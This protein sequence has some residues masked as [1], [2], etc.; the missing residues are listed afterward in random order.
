MTE[1]TRIRGLVL[2]AMVSM[3]AADGQLDTSEQDTICR[4]YQQITGKVIGEL[5]VAVVA[6]H[7]SK[8]PTKFASE[9]AVA[10]QNIET[11]EKETILRAA[12]LVLLADDRI[13]ARERKK[14][15]D[16]AAAMKISEIHYN[17][18]LEDL[19]SLT[20]D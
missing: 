2:Q 7:R 6:D 14:L 17:A 11:A 16:F 3:G 15:K 19:S 1:E 4:I 18:I 9:L 10:C 8:S 20:G 12:Y 13:S 5:E